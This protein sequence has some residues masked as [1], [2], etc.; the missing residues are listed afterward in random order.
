MPRIEIKTQVPPNTEIAD[1]RRAARL[2][3]CDQ[4]G[5]HIVEESITPTLSAT[6]TISPSGE[7]IETP[8]PNDH[9]VERTLTTFWDII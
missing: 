1:A 8:T 4:F 2:A 6:I 5:I 9:T 3:A 7:H